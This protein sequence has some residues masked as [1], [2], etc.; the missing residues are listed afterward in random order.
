MYAVR[1]TIASLFTQHG[2]EPKRALCAPCRGRPPCRATSVGRL[3]AAGQNVLSGAQAPRTR[4][5]RCLELAATD[6]GTTTLALIETSD[7]CMLGLFATRHKTSLRSAVR[8]VEFFAVV[9]LSDGFPIVS[10]SRVPKTCSLGWGVTESA[11]QFSTAQRRRRL[12][13][14]SSKTRFCS[15]TVKFLRK[16][17]FCFSSPLP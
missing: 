7:L 8:E 6:L 16:N 9:F 1:T 17:S 12:L 15:S 10:S 14:N 2:T 4:P 11:P 3:A 5:L 13:L